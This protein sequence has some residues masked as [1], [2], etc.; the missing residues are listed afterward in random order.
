MKKCVCIWMTALL[1]MTMFAGTALAYTT[2]S[3]CSMDCEKCGKK[4]VGT[5]TYTGT[6]TRNK[7]TCSVTPNCSIK[8]EYKKFKWNCDT[9]HYGGGAY[10]L[11]QEVHRYHTN[12][13]CPV[14]DVYLNSAPVVVV[15]K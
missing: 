5:L 15:S 4:T 12:A 7:G 13:S 3:K 9:C 10:G 14:K 2:G 6:V 1:L 11:E 8:S